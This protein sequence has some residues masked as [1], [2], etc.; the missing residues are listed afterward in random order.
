[1]NTRLPLLH[2]VLLVSVVALLALPFVLQAAEKSASYKAA[3]ESITGEDLLA[4]DKVLA[5]EKLEGREAGTPGGLEARKYLIEQYTKLKLQPAGPEG[6]FEQ[7]FMS[8]FCNIVGVIPGRDPALKNEYVLVEAHY[9]HV[10]HGGHGMSYDPGGIH[11]GAD[12][13]AS[14]SSALMEI[15]QAFTFL[16]EP[17]KRS[18]LILATDAEEKGLFG[19][20][21]WAAHPTVPLEKVVAG[22]NMDMIGRL[23]DDKL[24]V[25]GMRTGVG[26]RRLISEQNDDLRMNLDFNWEFKPNADY[27]PI[28]EKGVPVLMFHT[29]LHENYH[30]T[31]DT[32]D[33]LNAP[34]MS[35]VAR[36]VFC[37]VAELAERPERIAYR[38]GAK[39]E[40]ERTET[41]LTEQSPTPP[42]RLGVTVD[43]AVNN[44]LPGVRIMK[45]EADS[46]ASRA[47]LKEDD[48]ILEFSGREVQKCDDL[49][50]M[51]MTA[52]SPAKAVVRGPQEEK[53]REIQIDLAGHPMRLGFTWRVDE[54]EP[55]ALIVTHVVS[56]TP[57][58][59]VGMLPGDRIYQVAGRDFADENEFIGLA[60]AAADA[61]D[62]L[63]ERN[64]KIQAMHLNIK[65]AAPLKRAA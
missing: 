16:S 21:H 55:K 30:R 54:A 12:D 34:G 61:L 28:Y 51:V 29:G 1:M 35:R 41:L 15:V 64:G 7:P 56:G 24:Y 22:I 14:G 49:I 47:G 2:R 53:S 52:E 26:W 39:R 10:G 58:A 27:Y 4:R 63:I 45:I 36:L 13:N 33:R 31:S 6:K 20:K 17:P 11:P 18:V 9:D 25:Y 42:S 38:S 65:T 59:L 23:R 5:D 40:N 46:P 8:N 19:S 32:P 62:L 37:V 44:D 60:K 48:R 3:L 57:A 43:S 50:G